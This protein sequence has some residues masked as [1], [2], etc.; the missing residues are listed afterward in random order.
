[1]S[2]FQREQ[3]GKRID[4][5]V[6]KSPLNNR[7][8][9][10][11]VGVSKVTVGKWRK[12]E[13]EP[14]A[15]NVVRLAEVLNSSVEFITQ[16][17]LPKEVQDLL[18]QC[19]SPQTATE[20]DNAH[21]IGIDFYDV[22]ACCGDGDSIFEYEPLKEKLFFKP[23][24]FKKR[25]L[26]EKHCVMMYAKNDSMEYYICDGDAVMI[27]KSA[28]NV[29]DGQVYAVWFEGELMIKRIFK[30]GNGEL[31]LTADNK[32]YR[33]KEINQDNGDTFRI[34]GEVVYRSG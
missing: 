10:E 27:D 5:L 9:S 12:G 30:N 4:D 25:N 2:D 24:F 18:N 21:R 17:D 34:I 31:T 7:E 19:S 14:T 13:T 22:H 16:G 32:K 23:D 28:N 8:I 29:K 1:M 33:D 15:T 26:K 3:I 11:L 20:E 6:K